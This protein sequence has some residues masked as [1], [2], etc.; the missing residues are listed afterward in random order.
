[1]CNIEVLPMR[2]VWS[3]DLQEAIG[4]LRPA[5][6]QERGGAPGPGG[7]GAGLGQ[8]QARPPPPPTDGQER[9]PE[10]NLRSCHLRAQKSL[11]F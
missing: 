11:D 9:Q 6:Q 8:P 4:D 3:D 2:S 1:M 7:E 5:G 10:V